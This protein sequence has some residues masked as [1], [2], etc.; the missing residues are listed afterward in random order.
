MY[1]QGNKKNGSGVVPSFQVIFG[2]EM[3]G[4]LM[5]A[6]REVKKKSLDVESF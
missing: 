1:F 5:A 4:K 6:Y 2:R 3:E